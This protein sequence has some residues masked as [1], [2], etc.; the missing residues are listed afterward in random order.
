ME[1][2]KTY[3]TLQMQVKKLTLSQMEFFTFVNCIC[4]DGRKDAT[5]VSTK[6]DQKYYH[7][8]EMEEHYDIVGKPGKMVINVVL[9]LSISFQQENIM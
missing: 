6:V 3:I 4:I 9:V 7:K 1:H 2:G 5:L 8:V